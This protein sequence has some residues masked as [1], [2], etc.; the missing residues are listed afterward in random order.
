MASIAGKRAV[1][2]AIRWQLG[3]KSA[4]WTSNFSSILLKLHGMPG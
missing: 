3:G 2:N 1:P 4:F